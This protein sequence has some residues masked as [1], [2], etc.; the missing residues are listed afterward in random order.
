MKV[1]VEGAEDLVVR[2]GS[3][4]LG[5]SN[6]RPRIVLMELFDGNLSSFDSSI[7]SVIERMASF[8]YQPHVLKASGR[9]LAPYDVSKHSAFY[10]IVFLHTAR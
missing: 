2:G 4:I 8:G 6:R 3:S 1:D 5:D 7:S 9:R 10:N